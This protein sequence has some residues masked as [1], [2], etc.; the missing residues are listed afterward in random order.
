MDILIEVRN[1]IRKCKKNQSLYLDL[2]MSGITDLNDFPE[3]FECIH[4]ETLILSNSWI[5]HEKKK[6]LFSNNQGPKNIFESI[7][8][9]IGRLENLKKLIISN[10]IDNYG[11]KDVSCISKLVNLEYLDISGNKISQYDFLS[12]LIRL[13][14]LNLGGNLISDIHFLKQVPHLEILLLYRNSI[15]SIHVL[16]KFS[17]LHRLDIEANLISHLTPLK[18]LNQLKFLDA[19]INRISDLSPLENLNQLQSL[20]LNANS[21]SDIEPLKNL[22]NLKSLNLDTNRFSD[23]NPLKKLIQLNYLKLSNNKINDIDFLSN[24]S[25]LEYADLTDNNINKI[26]LSTFNL[27][28]GIDLENNNGYTLKFRNNPIELPP[29]EIIRQGRKSVQ[30]WYKAIKRE[31]NEIKIILIGDPKAGKTSLLRRLKGDTFNKE[32][33]Q[34][35]GINIEDIEFGK[36]GSFKNQKSLHKLTGHFWDFGGQEIM[37]ATHKFFLTNRSVYILVLDARKDANVAAQI[38]QW[39]KRIKATGGNS[40]IIVVANQVDINRGFGFVNEYD[41]QKEFPQIKYFIKTSCSTGEEIESIRVRLEELI[42]QA[43]LF[44]TAVDERW[45]NIKEKL[46]EE[47]KSNHFLD[48]ARFIK[49]CNEFGL[50]DKEAHKNAITFLHDLGLALHFEDLN[51]SEYYVLDPY[52]ITYGVYQIL[53]SSYAAK[54]KGIVSMDNLEF[55]VNEEDEKKEAYKPANY[56]KITYTINQRR[57]LVD[58]LNVFKLC[59]YLPGHKKFIIPDLLDTIEP[60]NITKHIREASDAIGFVFEYEYLP[61]SVIPNIMVETHQIVLEKWRTGMVLKYDGCK[62]L[63]SNYQNRLS[64]IVTGEYKKKREFM[65]IIRHV[66]NSVNQ[67]LSD[68]PKMLIPLPGISAFA[69]Y[70]VLL[71]RE[72]KR[73]QYFILDEDKPTEKQFEISMLLEGIP[74]QDEVRNISKKIDALLAND[75]DMKCDLE[76]VLENQEEIKEK[77][78]VHYQYLI[79]IPVNGNLKDEIVA[80]VKELNEQQ[81]GEITEAVMEWIAIGFDQFDGEMDSKLKQIYTDLKKSDNVEMKLKL[82]VPL[83]NLLGIELE[84]KFDVKS[85]AKKMYSQYKVKLF[86]LMES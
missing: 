41:L 7:P 33:V 76:R 53:T 51:L 21:I 69:E 4:L 16:E 26:P 44:N 6:R 42:P 38:K 1:R 75:K 17:N 34:T 86:K 61:K 81:S 59:Y 36:C 32:E 8:S 66:I 65:A 24:L 73:K 62:T 31:L 18:N 60:I 50:K 9:Q 68:K 40:P 19:G 14:Y 15:S 23:A 48:E 27:N 13:K 43:E 35:D 79:K 11:I 39:T 83:I 57:F 77:L 80:A 72:R 70:E 85:W 5:N 49:I 54:Q 10:G 12:T 84:T 37:N 28:L 78:D 3:L 58:I 47:T 63:I 29:I 82:S 2:G 45:I 46:Q 30:D 55:I 71:N 64:I 25:V 22:I 67:E 74:T 56:Q 20:N 52:W